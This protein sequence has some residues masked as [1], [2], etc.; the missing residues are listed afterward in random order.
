MAPS[1]DRTVTI[2]GSR[3]RGR[4]AQTQ[5]QPVRVL[6]GNRRLRRHSGKGGGRT[7]RRPAAPVEPSADA[8]SCG[9]RVISRRKVLRQVNRRRGLRVGPA[10][11]RRRW[12]RR[13]EVR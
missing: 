9:A 5:V 12:R 2:R 7:I 3:T 1:I 11:R 13:Q 10:S 6:S 4:Q 8:N